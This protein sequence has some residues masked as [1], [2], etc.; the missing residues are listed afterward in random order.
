MEFTGHT[1]QLGYL[2]SVNDFGIACSYRRVYG[3]IPQTLK[4]ICQTL[5]CINLCLHNT[6]ILSEDI[7]GSAGAVRLVQQRVAY[8]LYV[9][10]G[11]STRKPDI[12]EH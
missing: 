5:K 9:G 1:I 10:Q 6:V 2:V 4:R 11:R 8:P 12:S 7:M 3:H